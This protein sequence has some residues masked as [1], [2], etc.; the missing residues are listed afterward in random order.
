MAD[1]LRVGFGTGRGNESDAGLGRGPEPGPVGD[2]HVED[3]KDGV[4]AI[5][6]ER[7]PSYV[8]DHD[9]HV[10]WYVRVQYALPS[11]GLA[12][13][14]VMMSTFVPKFYTDNLHVSLSVLGYLS[15]GS[16]VFDAITDPVVGFLSDFTRS[17]WGRRRPWIFAGGLY[18]AAC[19]FGILAPPYG[20]SENQLVIW[21]CVFVMNIMMASTITRVPWYALGMELTH[22]HDEKTSVFATREAMYIVGSIFGAGLP[23]AINFFMG[24]VESDEDQRDQYV[25]LGILIGIV[26]AVSNVSCA[27]EVKERRYHLIPK[28][29]RG[30][31]IA[32]M[33][34]L[35]SLLRN[36]A[37]LTHDLSHY[38]PA[39]YLL[40]SASVYGAAT[41]TGAFFFSYYVDYVVDARD[42][43]EIILIIYIVTAIACIPL[44]VWL[45]KRYE[46]ISMARLAML[47]QSIVLT[48][49]FFFVREGDFARF[50]GAVVLAGIGFGGYAALRAS[51]ISDLSDVDEWNQEIRTH[52]R[53]EGGIQGLFDLNSKT[54][55]AIFTGPALVLLGKLG[56]VPNTAQNYESKLFIRSMYTLFPGI[57]GLVSI[58]MLSSYDLT[59]E[60]HSRRKREWGRKRQA[61]QREGQQ[62]AA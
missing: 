15:L 30:T 27:I 21:A 8:H 25:I 28:H 3:A 46:K 16:L 61:S 62:V 23:L 40:L 29:P 49:C 58:A 43:L 17:R 60:E 37:H 45:A 59:R 36:Y 57:L 48:G 39:R 38:K 35:S 10:S 50:Q 34:G 6:G 9:A 51:L 54:L 18:L 13:V 1:D 4:L 41:Y 7:Q 31:S 32:M 47:I 2:A 22:L 53:R 14:Q 55:S 56:Y 33:Y 20:L 11:L 52:V 26:T 44:W 5:H 24:D 19:I 12:A 42:Y